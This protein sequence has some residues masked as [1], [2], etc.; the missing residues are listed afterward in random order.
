MNF[1]ALN[2]V[3]VNGWDRLYG[4][5]AVGM[6]MDVSAEISFA[7][8]GASNAHMQVQASASGTRWV[9][10]RATAAMSFDA[11]AKGTRWAL[12]YASS[13]S[14]LQV[15][16]EGRVT[17]GQGAS[18]TMRLQM[19]ASGRLPAVRRSDS[20][21]TMVLGLQSKARTTTPVLGR[22]EAQL[23]V[24]TAANGRLPYTTNSSDIQMRIDVS[25]RSRSSQ[26]VQGSALMQMGLDLARILP[27]Q[28]RL[29]HGA[30]L[31]GMGIDA[32]LRMPRITTLPA[33]NYPAPKARIL[34]V[35]MDN[36]AIRVP[37]MERAKEL[38]E[39]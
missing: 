16:A 33:Q 9:L 7:R 23:W 4:D 35:S 36:R 1:Y 15:L 8:F 5:A 13:T 24:D 30:A 37:K 34:S 28:Y 6:S 3:P 12:G 32:K 19:L 2:G 38:A 20:S 17:K 29:A 10:G 21:L 18:I 25:A 26:R 11:K 39:A 22:S 27:R 14:E 31:L